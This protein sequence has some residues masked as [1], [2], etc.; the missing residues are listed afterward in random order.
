M[1]GPGRPEGESLE[2]KQDGDPKSGRDFEQPVSG[3]AYGLFFRVVATAMLLAVL[4]MAARAALQAPVDTP[5]GDRFGILGLGLFALAA[6]YWMMIRATT[7]ID[8]AGIR[9]SG[10][11]E[12]KVAWSEVYSARLFGPPFARRLLVRTINGR[13]RFFF[14][15]T[16]ELHA[17]FARIVQRF[18]T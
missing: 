2:R 5:L 11:I 16:P 10:L 1:S 13:F 17:A 6:S 15:G 12:T 14:G 18:R 4:A 7:T 9:Q 8:D 3:P